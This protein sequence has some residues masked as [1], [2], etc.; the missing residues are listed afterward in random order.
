MVFWGLK[1]IVY[2]TIYKSLESLKEDIK[3]ILDSI[4]FQ[5]TIRYNYK[6]TISEYL[7][8]YKIYKDYNFNKFKA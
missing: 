3:N 4:V 1:N 5:K 8:I 2:K 6:E 7:K